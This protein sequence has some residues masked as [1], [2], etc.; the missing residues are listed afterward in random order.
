MQI[1]VRDLF[2]TG[3]C[4]EGAERGFARRVGDK[5]ARAVGPGYTEAVVEWPSLLR[6]RSIGSYG[7]P[8][9]MVHGTGSPASARSLS[10]RR[11]KIC[12][13]GVG[14]DGGGNGGGGCC[15]QAAAAMPDGG[16]VQTRVPR[17]VVGSVRILY[18]DGD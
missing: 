5:A 15:S 17:K 14:T 3:A 18:G 6:K 10:L 7:K 4:N 8:S 2:A 9:G 16:L 1:R 11:Q 12:H 13:G